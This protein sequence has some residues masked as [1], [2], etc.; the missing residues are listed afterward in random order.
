MWASCFA[1]VCLFIFGKPFVA[2]VI[3]FGLDSLDFTMNPCNLNLSIGDFFAYTLNCTFLVLDLAFKFPSACVGFKG[4]ILCLCLGIKHDLLAFRLQGVYLALFA[5]FRFVVTTDCGSYIGNRLVDFCNLFVDG[6]N[7][8]F[9]CVEIFIFG[10]HLVGLVNPWLDL[11][12]FIFQ[13]L[14]SCRQFGFEVRKRFAT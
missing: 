6:F 3:L 12:Q 2:Q 14:L 9:D 13:S 8:N 7:F 5:L 4:C 1:I 10:L 11:C